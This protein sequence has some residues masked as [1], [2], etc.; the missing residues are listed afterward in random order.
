[1]ADRRRPHQES[2]PAQSGEVEVRFT[3]SALSETEVKLAHSG[4]ERHGVAGEAYRAE[5]ASEYGGP[6][7]LARFADHAGRG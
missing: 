4:F 6:L 7:I 3:P 2:D 1:M 5:M